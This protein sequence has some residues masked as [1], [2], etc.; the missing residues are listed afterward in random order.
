MLFR[1]RYAVA[2]KSLFVLVR[3]ELSKSKIIVA[4][5]LKSLSHCNVFC[6]WQHYAGLEIFRKNFFSRK[7]PEIWQKNVKSKSN[8]MHQ[9]E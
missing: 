8:V 4:Y 7:I 9:Q 1:M 2:R 3:V 6:T 5:A